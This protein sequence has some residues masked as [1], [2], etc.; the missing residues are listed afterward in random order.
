MMN[1]ENKVMNAV[2]NLMVCPRHPGEACCAN[3]AY[4][5]VESCYECLIGDSMSVLN[6]Q[7][8]SQKP[9]VSLQEPDY[10][11]QAANLL[12]MIG[13][14]ANLCGYRHIMCAIRLA[15]NDNSYLGQITCRLYPDVAKMNS[16]TS[17]R[18]ERGIRHA[19]EVAWDRIDIDLITQYFGSTVSLAKGKPTNSEFIAAIVEHI[20]LN[21]RA[22]SK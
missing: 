21:N 17:S 6:K 19:I 5:G 15:L 3:C 2:V 9:A 20:R 12:R 13:V 18:V 14:P 1:K 7:F 11:L 8:C 4:A 10:E 16:T 22:S